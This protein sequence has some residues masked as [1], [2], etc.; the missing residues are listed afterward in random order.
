M[1]E[2][3]IID[4]VTYWTN[5]LLENG[6]RIEKNN[7]EQ[8]PWSSEVYPWSVD[9]IHMGVRYYTED[10]YKI[11][12]NLECSELIDYEHIENVMLTE[13]TMSS[14]GKGTFGYTLKKEERLFVESFFKGDWL[15]YLDIQGSRIIVQFH[16]D[17]YYPE[18][19][20]L[21][22]RKIKNNILS[23]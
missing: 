2:Q 17:K 15:D 13:N 21:K 8:Y 14:R 1:K 20:R 11:N 3:L 12:F 23:L 9:I 4:I 5:I 16:L 19:R 18:F 7:K 10:T 6:I 22:I